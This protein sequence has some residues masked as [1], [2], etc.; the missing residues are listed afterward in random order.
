MR[1]ATQTSEFQNRPRV[2]R[3]G[4]GGPRGYGPRPRLYSDAEKSAHLEERRLEDEATR[5]LLESQYGERAREWRPRRGWAP[6][7][8]S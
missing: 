6:P 1:P 5:M 2:F 7:C 8:P 3:T 4:H